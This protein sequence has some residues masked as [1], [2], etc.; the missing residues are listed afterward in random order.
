MKKKYNRKNDMKSIVLA[1]YKNIRGKPCW[2]H[3][4]FTEM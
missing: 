2:A 4:L 1:Y 3:S